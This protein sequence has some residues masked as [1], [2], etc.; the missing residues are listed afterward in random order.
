MRHATCIR[1]G[2]LNNERPFI[3]KKETLNSYLGCLFNKAFGKNTCNEFRNKSLRQ[4][5]LDIL[6]EYLDKDP[7]Q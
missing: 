5:D 1:E 7:V 3:N 6:P 2:Y 4:I